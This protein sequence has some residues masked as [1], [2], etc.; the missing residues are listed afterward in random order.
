LHWPPAKK[1][2][3][4]QIIANEPGVLA[5]IEEAAWYFTNFGLAVER[6][7]A[8]GQSVK[9]GQVDFAPGGR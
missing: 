8:D 5:G 2:A 3:V 9:P 4:A 1:N 7:G 6:A